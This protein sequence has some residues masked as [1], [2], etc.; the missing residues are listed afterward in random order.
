[1]KEEEKKNNEGNGKKMKE[2]GK[3][4]SDDNKFNFKTPEKS[5][6]DKNCPFHGNLRIRG[7]IFVGEVVSDKMSKTVSVQWGRKFYL[8]KFERYEKRRS[9]VKAH[10]PECINAKKGDIVKIAECKP[11]SKTKH[12][13]VVEI[14]NEKDKGEK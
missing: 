5:C 4:R 13:V 6:N 11:I 14:I 9:K 12:F 1:M 10:N 3:I 7:R 8:P 2:M